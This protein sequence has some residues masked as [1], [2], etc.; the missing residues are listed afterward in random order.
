[1]RS[2]HYSVPSPCSYDPA[3]EWSNAE[4]MN[5]AKVEVAQRYVANGTARSTEHLEAPELASIARAVVL[6][7]PK[8]WTEAKPKEVRWAAVWGASTTADTI[9]REL[10]RFY[11]GRDDVPYSE[12][13]DRVAVCFADGASAADVRNDAVVLISA[14]LGVTMD[15][16][17]ATAAYLSHRYSSLQGKRD[18][19]LE[20]AAAYFL[21]TPR[22]RFMLHLGRFDPLAHTFVQAPNRTIEEETL[23]QITR[24]VPGLSAAALALLSEDE[25]DGILLAYASVE[26]IEHMVTLATPTRP[27]NVAATFGPDATTESVYRVFCYAT[28]ADAVAN[29]SMGDLLRNTVIDKLRLA[30]RTT[31]ESM[32]D[33][34]A[35]YLER[36]CKWFLLSPLRRFLFS[37]GRWD[38][39]RGEWPSDETVVNTARVEL[40]TRAKRADDA[41]AIPT[42]T[43]SALEVYAAKY[44]SIDAVNRLR[45]TAKQNV[46]NYERMFSAAATVDDI[47]Y[48]YC[49]FSGLRDA[50]EMD[51]ETLRNSALAQIARQ[52]KMTEVEIQH[53]MTMMHHSH[54]ALQGHLHGHVEQVRSFDGLAPINH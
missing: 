27:L 20:S 13:R 6:E 54:A 52:F 30:L 38:P 51:S 41:A 9:Y 1:M 44:T 46:V 10:C 53:H 14:L 37:I 17:D 43:I 7:I 4:V 5:T 35:A 50:A 15:A 33:M 2:A 45:T 11:G 22:K 36:N 26:D 28:H 21:L 39:D 40:I 16:L 3:L 32:Q 19:Y 49:A 24:L 12:L 8:I 31:T 34:T 25:L 18:G 48:E 42:A 47:L 29:A 23:H